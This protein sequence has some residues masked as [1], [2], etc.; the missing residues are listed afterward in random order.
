M[1]LRARHDL[2]PGKSTPPQGYIIL[3]FWPP[4]FL[5]CP[6]MEATFPI[7]LA[8][9]RYHNSRTEYLEQKTGL[10]KICIEQDRHSFCAS[11]FPRRVHK[12]RSGTQEKT[13]ISSHRCKT[14]S[15]GKV[16][17]GRLFLTTDKQFKTTDH[18]L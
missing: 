2:G 16:E 15:G 8:D 18:H 13:E 3:I 5:A 7:G 10:C 11:L 9:N 14:E 12:I 4:T 17:A 1:I 6:G